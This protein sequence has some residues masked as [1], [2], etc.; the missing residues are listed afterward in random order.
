MTS[1]KRKLFTNVDVFAITKELDQLLFN[2]TISNIYE[3][4]DLLILKLRTNEGKKNLIIKSDTRI[5]LTNYDYP[6]PKYPSQYIIYLRKL[7]N[8]CSKNS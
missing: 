4:E 2:S 5:N 8:R 6:I 1:E 3:I 7:L